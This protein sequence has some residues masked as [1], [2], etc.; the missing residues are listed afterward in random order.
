LAWA[1]DIDGRYVYA[2]DAAV[3]VFK[4]AREE[5]YDRTDDEVFPPE[6][7]AQFKHNDQLALTSRAGVHVVETLRHED[8][9]EHHSLVSK[10]PIAGANGDVTLIGGIAIDITELKQAQLALQA[11]EQR[12]RLALDAGRMGVWEWNLESNTIW[13]SGNLETIHGLAPGSFSGTFEAFESLIHP[14]DRAR[15]HAAIAK[16]I[17]QGGDYDI[18]FRNVWSDG[19]VHWMAGKGK[20]IP[21]PGGKST[22]MIGVALD[23]TDRRRA[24]DALREADQRKD[25]FLATLAHELRNPLA[26]L[27]NSLQLLRMAG[28]DRAVQKQAHAVMGRQLQQMVRLVDDLL[29]VS[30]ITRNRLELRKTDIE[31]AA[32]IESAVEIS[33]PVLESLKHALILDLPREPVYLHADLTR[34]AQVIAN[35]LNNAAKYS[36]P[37]S[38]IRLAVTTRD[39]EVALSVKDNGIGID[40]HDLPKL[41]QI[42]SQLTSALDRAQ[43]GLGIGLA[44]VRGLVEMHGGRVEAHSDGLGQGS[45]FVVRLPTAQQPSERTIARADMSKNVT[46]RHRVLVVDD[47]EDSATTL[48][49]TLEF[50]GHE[51]QTAYDGASAL[52]LADSWRPDVILLDIGLPNLNGYEVAQRIRRQAWGRTIFLVA[53]TGW[54]QDHDKQRAK[55]AGFDRHL[56]KPVDFTTLHQ[57]LREARPATS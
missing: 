3:K 48:G 41:F 22:R 28:E 36:N 27:Q 19:S 7:A 12:L 14:E 29:D 50:A 13:W 38:T 42:F 35:L 39:D 40:P 33:R 55:A 51:T 52:E 10:F 21:E 25:E 46:N 53:L 31:L 54:G 9:I 24:E 1:K 8:G 43:G 26:P 2:N 44:L 15:V 11:S 16:A 18:E 56:T 45:E 47:N 37:G 57:L 34:L 17:E 5:L 20:L 30:R 32:A 49:M 6:T 23:V 4:T